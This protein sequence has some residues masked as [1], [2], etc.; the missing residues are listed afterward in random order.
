MEKE[1]IFKW[2]W[3][4]RKIFEKRRISFCRG[5]ETIE[6]EKDIWRRRLYF[7][8]EKENIWR[9]KYISC[10]GEEKRRGK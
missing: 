3:K 1:N 5:K 8:E 10:R 2:R 7:L 6:V 4:R 9:R